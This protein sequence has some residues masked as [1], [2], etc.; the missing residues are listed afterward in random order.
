MKLLL[1]L[2]VPCPQAGAA[3]A[4]IEARD[5]IL[6]R[7]MGLGLIAAEGKVS[8][9]AWRINGNLVGSCVTAT[10]FNSGASVDGG[11]GTGEAPLRNGTPVPRS[12][13]TR[14]VEEVRDLQSSSLLE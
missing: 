12:H 13:S 8:A 2:T 4:S 14:Q 10:P 7:C 5:E 9:P 6:N 1:R 3:A 11:R